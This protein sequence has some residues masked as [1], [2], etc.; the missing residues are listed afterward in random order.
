MATTTKA[1]PKATIPEDPPEIQVQRA[2]STEWVHLS[3]MGVTALTRFARQHR[4]AAQV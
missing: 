1:R 2:A 3:E 4:L